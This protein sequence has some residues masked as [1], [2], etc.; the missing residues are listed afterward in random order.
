MKRTSNMVDRNLLRE[1]DVS[2]DELSALVMGEDGANTLETQARALN[3]TQ[4]VRYI[5]S[6]R[7]IQ[8]ANAAGKLVLGADGIEWFN[9]FVTDDR[10]VP[11]MSS[12]YA[13][14]RDIHRLNLLRGLPKHYTFS[15]AGGGPSWNIFF[16]PFELPEQL[17]VTLNSLDIH[18]FRL[19]MCAEP[20]ERNLEL[21][22]QVVL[23]AGDKADV[24]P[25]S[26]N[27]CWPQ[28]Q[29]DRSDRL[30]FPCGSLTHHTPEHVGYNFRFPVSLVRDGWNEI[31]VEN[32]GDQSITVVCLELA[33]RTKQSEA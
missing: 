14:L 21:I 4:P 23:K 31:V 5:S 17:P 24:L 7:E 30:L 2:D 6:S 11:G 32:G 15:K 19:P 3:F 1:F 12:D 27:G 10:R 33:I 20:L 13:S 25:V 29:H 9:F 18:P 28:L 26:I 16:P 8:R 22:V